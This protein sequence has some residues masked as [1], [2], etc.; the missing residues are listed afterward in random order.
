M[1]LMQ[2]ISAAVL[3]FSSTMLWAESLPVNSANGFSCSQHGDLVT[4]RGTFPGSASPI[5][6]ATGREVVW[7]RAEYP[8]KRYTYYSDS[9]CL[10]ESEFQKSGKVKTQDCTS[11]TGERKTFKGGKS[12]AEWC[13]GK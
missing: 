3:I 5:L 10:C 6:E 11:K 4:C 13:G 12:T 1:K 8:G 9:G 2:W 7:L